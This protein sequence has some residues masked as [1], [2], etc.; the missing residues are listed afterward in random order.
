MQ[1]EMS[2][3]MRVWDPNVEFTL[4]TKAELCTTDT[5]LCAASFGEARKAGAAERDEQ[6][7]ERAHVSRIGHPTS[8]SLPGEHHK[9]LQYAPT[10]LQLAC[11]LPCSKVIKSVSSSRPILDTPVKARDLPSKPSALFQN[12]QNKLSSPEDSFSTLETKLI[13][14][15][16]HTRVLQHIEHPT[17]LERGRANSFDTESLCLSLCFVAANAKNYTRTWLDHVSGCSCCLTNTR[18]VSPCYLAAKSCV[19]NATLSGCCQGEA[20]TTGVGSCCELLH[21]SWAKE[22]CL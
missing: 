11:L 7:A 14:H 20:E 21:R 2:L 13:I 22:V 16:S 10:T 1:H 9:L 6:H 8:A 12:D 17:K 3:G 19:S 5:A 15:L 18:G 4:L